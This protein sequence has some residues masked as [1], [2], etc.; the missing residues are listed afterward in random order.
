NTNIKLE[1]TLLDKLYNFANLF[2]KEKASRLPLYYNI[3][4]H[5]IKLKEGLDRKIPKLL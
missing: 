2:N 3:A 1:V 5:Y 4:E